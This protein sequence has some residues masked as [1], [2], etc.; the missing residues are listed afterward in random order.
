MVYAKQG[1]SRWRA[2]RKQIRLLKRADEIICISDHVLSDLRRHTRLE[3]PAIRIHNGVNS[4][5]AQ[6]Q[7]PIVE[8][9]QQPYLFHIGRMTPNK[10]VGCLINLAEHWPDQQFAFAG[11][12]SGYTEGFQREAQAR[13]LTN[14]RF[15]F[16][17]SESQKAWLYSHCEALLMP[18]LTEGFGLPAIEAMYFGRPV[19]LSSL[20][21][22]P[23]IGG[24]TARYFQ[25]FEPASMMQT[26][27]SGLQDLSEPGNEERI[28]AWAQNFT[29]DKCIRRYISRY[30]K[31]LDIP[32]EGVQ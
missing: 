27:Q 22:L 17:I 11:P 21:S 14:V 18:S 26:I 32:L 25:D 12:K 9:E 19:F 8:L 24:E 6:P 3:T 10:N 20:T 16:D 31:A 4:L 29:W 23:E 28:K 7:T 5:A 2:L 13:G 30:A 15:L 1:F